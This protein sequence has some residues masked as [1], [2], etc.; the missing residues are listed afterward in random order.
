MSIAEIDCFLSGRSHAAVATVAADGAPRV[1]PA[2][3]SG[4]CEDLLLRPSGPRAE[5][6]MEE[7]GTF[8]R[9]FR[10]ANEFGTPPFVAVATNRK[11]GS[12][13]VVPLGY[14]H[15]DGAIY[16]TVNDVRALRK[17]LRRDPRVALGIFSGAAPLRA[18]VAEGLAV[19]VDDEGDEISRMI[20][21]RQMEAYTWLDFDSYLARWLEV[22]RTVYRI[23][24]DRL[25]GWT[26]ADDRPAARLD[27][28]TDDPRV[29]FAA[30]SEEAPTVVTLLAG[31]VREEGAGYRLLA[32]SR[33]AWDS[34]KQPPARW[35][36]G[37]GSHVEGGT[38]LPID[39]P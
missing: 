19:P 2:R 28:D 33:S 27:H 39:A 14:V 17:R 5:L 11:D 20:F 7:I 18:V 22:G 13:L 1:V 38:W 10:Y 4:G 24:P 12:P 31:S 9:D 8:L 34:R 16:L 35:E 23:D 25:V 21:A 29:C 15:H 30:F 37:K 32:G 26:D 36:K 3:F 6:T